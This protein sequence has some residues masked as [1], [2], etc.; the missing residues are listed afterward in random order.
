MPNNFCA[1]CG[2]PVNQTD[3]FCKKCGAKLKK[4]NPPSVPKEKPTEEHEEYSKTFFRLFLWGIVLN[5]F[6]SA[7]NAF[8]SG[9]LWLTALAAL[10]YYVYIFCQTTEKAMQSI[11]KKNWWPLG[12]LVLVPFG[13]WIAYFVIRHQLKKQ[14]RW[15]KDSLIFIVILT[16]TIIAVIGILATIVMVSLNSARTKA[17]EIR[18]ISD[19][20]Q[21]QLALESYHNTNGRYPSFLNYLTNLPEDILISDYRYCASP[22][23]GYHLGI[24]LEDSSLSALTQDDD[25]SACFSGTDPVLDYIGIVK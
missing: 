18:K 5:I 23:V 16:V 17:R 7:C 25:N 9:L 11:G 4:E 21:I 14:N 13:F 10:G 2:A 6:L 22:D 12:L 1:N 15:G 19:T 3:V 8:N 24:E 20:R